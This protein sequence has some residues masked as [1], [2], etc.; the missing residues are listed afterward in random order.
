MSTSALIVAAGRAVRFG[1]DM[2][3]QFVDVCGRPL[4]SWTIDR[5][6]RAESIDSIVVVV[7]EEFADMTALRVIDPYDF[8]KVRKVVVG[9]QTRQESVRNGLEALE[10]DTT[11]VAIHDGARPLVKPSDIDAVVRAAKDNLCAMLAARVTD[12]V[13]RV[14][15]LSVKATVDRSDLWLAQTPQVFEYGL[16]AGLHRTAGHSDASDDAVMVEAAGH[17][18]RIVESTGPNVKVTTP[19]DLVIVEAFLNRERHG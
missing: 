8:L 3:K 18:V 1:G 11:A 4:L 15:D 16:I 9:G 7:S 2:P 19:D 14:H 6:E 5:F 10:S 17:A 13:K 12:T